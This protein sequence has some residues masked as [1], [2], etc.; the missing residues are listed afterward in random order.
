MSV[1]AVTLMR[2]TIAALGA[3][4][5][6]QLERLS[7]QASGLTPA[8]AGTPGDQR[9]LLVLRQ[10]LDE[11]LRTTACNLRVLAGLRVNAFGG[12]T[13]EFDEGVRWAR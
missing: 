8:D 12:G 5:A 3:M 13:G 7:T 6:D 10:T 2:Q 1:A 11:L 4:D 9:Q